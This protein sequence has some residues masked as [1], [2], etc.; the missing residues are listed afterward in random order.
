[1]AGDWIKMR[2]WLGRDPCV[3]AM[4]DYLAGSRAFMNWLTDP[5][6][7]SCK[8]SAYEH[9]T[10]N[11]TVAL[12]VTSLLVT[13]GTARERGDRDG[14]DL[15]LH[16]ADF[17]T[18]DAMTDVP[19]FG[20]AMGFVGWAKEEDGAALRFPKFFKDHESPDEK[21]KRQA[22]ERQAKFR[23]KQSQQSNE[24]V[25]PP[26]NVTVTHRE[27]KRREVKTLSGKPDGSAVKVLDYLNSVCGTH[28][29]PIEANLRM[30]RGRLAEHGEAALLRVVEAKAAEWKGTEQEKYLRPET[31]FNAKKCGSYAG[32]LNGVSAL[33]VDA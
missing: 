25:T 15:V 28:Y 30:I 22:A 9:V 7:Q 1:M 32:Q 4:A 31:L 14:D 26:S 20:D 10:R 23:E 18:L 6:R 24:E 13:W 8:E 17:T 3:I 19:D 16:H 27:E 11:V 5:V 29:K 33:K 12:C 21:H 2:V